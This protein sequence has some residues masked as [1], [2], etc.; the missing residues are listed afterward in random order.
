[1]SKVL[2]AYFSTKGATAKVAE[3]LCKAENGDLFEIKPEKPYTDA[4]LDYKVKDS[5]SNL[6]MADESCR[7]GIIGKVDDMGQYDAVFVGE[8][9]I[10]GTRRNKLSKLGVFETNCPYF[11]FSKT[12]AI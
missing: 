8:Y 12:L 4:D 11:Y 7:P 9:D 3:E 6:E 10:I 5:R 1:M 2:V